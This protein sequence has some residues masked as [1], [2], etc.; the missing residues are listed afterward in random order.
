MKC[1]TTRETIKLL[2]KIQRFQ[3]EDAGKHKV[4]VAVDLHKNRVYFT[5]WAFVHDELVSGECYYWRT[6][7]ENKKGVET[8]IEKVANDIDD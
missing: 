4:Y 1:T 6:F 2:R 5:Y 8:F 7:E 3:I